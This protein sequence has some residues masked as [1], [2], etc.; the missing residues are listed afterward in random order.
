MFKIKLEV[1]CNRCDCVKAILAS[2]WHVIFN[3]LLVS[4][5]VSRFYVAQ[6]IHSFLIK[7][8]LLS[9]LCYLLRL[10]FKC[11]MEPFIPA[12]YDLINHAL[13]LYIKE[14]SILQEKTSRKKLLLDIQILCV[15]MGTLTVFWLSY[16]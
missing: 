6:G 13:F 16:F 4:C 14:N 2:S 1:F 5:P 3:V 11:K 12:F 15:S 9:F 10:L 7:I 8:I